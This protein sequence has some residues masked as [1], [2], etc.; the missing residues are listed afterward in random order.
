MKQE[1]TEY[2]KNILFSNYNIELHDIRLENPPKADMWDMA[3]GCFLLAKD[4]KKSPNA[5]AQELKM[6]I[7]SDDNKTSIIEK[8]E[9][10]GPY[11]NI[12][13]WGASYGEDFI[14]MMTAENVYSKIS[15]SQDET[16]YIDYIGA[17]V[18]K[19]LHIGHMCTPSQW[20]VL[21]NL[22]T[23]LG[24]NTISDSHLGDWGIIFWKL[25]VAYKKYWNKAV[26]EQDAVEHLFELYVKI[27]TD[28]ETDETLDEQF[29][30]A[31]KL[32]SEWEESSVEIWGSFTRYSIEAMEIQLSRLFVSPEYNIWESFYEWI[33]LPKMWKFPDLDISM[34]EIVEELLQKWIAI[35][36]DD[37][38]VWVVFPDE[39]KIPSCILRKRDGTH[40]YLASDLASIK[41]RMWN[42]APKKI[43][44]FVDV[45]QQLHLRQ[46]FEISKLAHWVGDDTELTHAHNGF[47]SLKDGAMSTR[48]G[49][50][51]KLEK[52]LNEAESRA[53]KIILEK[54]DDIKWE[55]LDE[56][57]RTI[58]IGAIKYGYLKKSRESDVIF[59]WGEFMSFEWNSG[60]YIQYAYVRALWILRKS[61]TKPKY[62][63][64]SFQTESEKELVKHIG[65]FTKVIEN[66]TETYHPHV[67]CKYVYDMTKKFS[68]L[69]NQVNILAE[70]NLELRNSRLA[71]LC[72]FVKILEESFEILAIPLPKEM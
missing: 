55:E 8:V 48:T 61:D 37:N 70:P 9:V 25:I 33:W 42:W 34:S 45:R 12:F 40:W 39:M 4:L 38:S 3:F 43:V 32:L 65:E 10:A 53:K 46:A 27:S 22:F 59:D 6:S 49:K 62:E 18:W 23:K 21:V 64:L 51:I 31:F 19:P 41:Y 60:P 20:Q 24:Y 66:M 35:Q 5:I 63:N 68:S 58:W 54:R 13:L 26:L 15:A 36:N 72:G 44:Y 47:I 52:L 17:N 56:L 28:A 11:L 16:V 50:I 14:T 67:L 1:I 29:R 69:Y 7:D 57:A 2:L 30:N 71:L